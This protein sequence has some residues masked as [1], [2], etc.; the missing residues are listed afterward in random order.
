[1]NFFKK[2][3][4]SIYS[5]VFYRELLDK[6]LKSSIRY[7]FTLIL[8]LSLVFTA[9]ISVTLIP[10]LHSFFSSL[11]TKVVAY[12]P[13][14]LQV[15]IKD[16]VASTNVIEP[17]FLQIPEELKDSN[18]VSEDS[19]RPENLLVID[20]QHDFNL[21]RFTDQS[22]FALLTEDSLIYKDENGKVTIQSLKEIPDVVITKDAVSRWM[23]SLT[24]F[25]K[26]LPLL[27]PIVFFVVGFVVSTFKL[28]YFFVAALLVWLVASI[29]KVKITY[30]K[31]YQ[32]TIH[33]F[34]LPLLLDVVLKIFGGSSI[35][36]LPTILLLVIVALNLKKPQEVSV[37]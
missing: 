24:P 3:G 13:E 8:L 25:L 14:E 9:V 23:T 11:G 36:F 10:N 27:L 18:G 5:P 1:M 20:T 28:I 12:Y 22:T 16:G 31:A 4:S 34:T 35:F 17:Y 33:A 7:F 26:V 6:P 30:K 29:K 2:V 37:A 19:F 21:T 15:T 32:I